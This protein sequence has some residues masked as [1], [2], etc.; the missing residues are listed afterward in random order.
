MLS[1]FGKSRV[2]IAARRSGNALIAASI[3][4][5]TSF[6]MKVGADN[7]SGI[8]PGKY[9]YDPLVGMKSATVR[10]RNDR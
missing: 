7:P 2:A 4:S 9:E 3:A 5:A 1:H 6:G 10:S 8:D